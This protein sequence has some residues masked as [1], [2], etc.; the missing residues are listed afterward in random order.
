MM[1]TVTANLQWTVGRVSI[2]RIEERIIP[3]A[4]SSL[5]P[6]GADLVERCRPWIDPFVSDD[7]SELLLSI[8]SFVVETPEHLIVVDTCI[9]SSDDSVFAG[10]PGF[11]ARLA[12]A[13][14]GGLAAVDVVVCTH[15]HFDH[16]GWNT[17]EVDGRHRPRFVNACYLVTETELGVERDAQDTAAAARSIDPLR[18]AGCLD[19]VQ[20]DHRIDQWVT[21]EPSPGHTPGHVSVRI[22]DGDAVAVITGDFVHSP[23]QLAHPRAGSKSDFDASMAAATRERYISE[24]TNSEILVLG[25]HFAPPTGGYI[26]TATEGVRFEA[27]Q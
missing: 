8:H 24:L 10:D 22:A 18:E 9:G 20:P 4:W 26:E 2:T 11:G 13:L 25:T 16:V 1:T 15:L 12:A 17:I 6:A 14:P 5:I 7:A 21:L 3:L 23:L 27:G 19:A